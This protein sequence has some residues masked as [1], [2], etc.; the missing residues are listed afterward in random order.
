MNWG[1]R[2]LIDQQVIEHRSCKTAYQG[3]LQE[4]DVTRVRE[5]MQGSSGGRSFKLGSEGCAGVNQTK[6]K[7]AE[8]LCEGRGDAHG[9]LCI[10]GGRVKC[11]RD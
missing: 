7:M 10:V 8:C 11:T 3:I 2:Q 6:G 4:G 9:P 1:A 5:E